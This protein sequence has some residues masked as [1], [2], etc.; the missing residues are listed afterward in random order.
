MASAKTFK[1]I[2]DEEVQAQ[3]EVEVE[4]YEEERLML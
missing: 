3:V 4:D 2:N 1:I